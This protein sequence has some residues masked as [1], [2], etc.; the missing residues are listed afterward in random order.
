MKINKLYNKE[1]KPIN[2]WT[3]DKFIDYEVASKLKEE[4]N[5][6]F[7]YRK[8]EFKFFNRNGSAMYEWCKYNHPTHPYVVL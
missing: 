3:F 1:T 4:L 6:L 2:H 7:E 5:N 8:N